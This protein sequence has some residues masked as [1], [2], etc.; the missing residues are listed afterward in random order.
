MK[1]IKFSKVKGKP[2]KEHL[3]LYL[4]DKYVEVEERSIIISYPDRMQFKKFSMFLRQYVFNTLSLD[5]ENMKIF[6]PKDYIAY[7]KN[8]SMKF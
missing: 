4:E 3:I 1:K 6:I 8:S 7:C 2:S 5:V